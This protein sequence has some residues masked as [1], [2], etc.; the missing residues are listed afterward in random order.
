MYGDSLI[1]KL[2]KFSVIAIGTAAALTLADKLS[3]GKFGMK[4]D[5]YAI[6]GSLDE[7]DADEYVA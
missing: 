5:A 2:F 6:D 1:D 4:A 7:E 3:G